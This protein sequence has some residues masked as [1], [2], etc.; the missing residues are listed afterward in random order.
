VS[1]SY[2]SNLAD[3][4]AEAPNGTRIH[5]ARVPQQLPRLPGEPRLEGVAIL[6]LYSLDAWARLTISDRR[7]RFVAGNETESI[8]PENELLVV[9]GGRPS[10]RGR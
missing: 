9:V 4:I 2:L 6:A 8:V 5:V 1:E 3:R 7:I 10:A